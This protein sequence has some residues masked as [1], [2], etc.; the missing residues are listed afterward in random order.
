[1]QQVHNRQLTR[2]DL[3]HHRDRKPENYF[4][5]NLSSDEVQLTSAW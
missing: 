4:E 5:I 3:K 1:M 2:K